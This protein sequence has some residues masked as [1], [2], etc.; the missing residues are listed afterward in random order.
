[1]AVSVALI[2]LGTAR[3]ASAQLPTLSLSTGAFV[4]TPT[5]GDPD[6][7]PTLTSPVGAISI[8]YRIRQSDSTHEWHLM[9]RADG[10]LHTT[11][12]TPIATIPSAN[13]TWHA[14]AFGTGFGTLTNSDVDLASGSGNVNPERTVPISFSLLNSWD[15]SSG[16]YTQTIIV[17]LVVL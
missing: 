13:T 17:T 5:T 7:A 12:T 9:I 10:D 14:A 15:Y 2:A 6:S 1:M 16:T 4:Y 8:S 3:D 11:G